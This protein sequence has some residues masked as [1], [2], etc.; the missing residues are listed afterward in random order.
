MRCRMS[1]GAVHLTGAVFFDV[2]GLRRGSRKRRRAD[3]IVSGSSPTPNT[4]SPYHVVTQ[5]ALLGVGSSA[6]RHFRLSAGDV[7]VVPHGDAHAM[8]SAPACAARRTWRFRAP[9]DGQLPFAISMGDRRT[10]ILRTWSADTLDATRGRS[11]RCC[12]AAASHPRQRSRGRGP[13]CIRRVRGRGIEGARTGGEVCSG[14]S[15][16]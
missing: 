1:C 9:S 2:R 14:D 4:S 11:T 13:R 3:S 16:S 8:S 6:R 12:R 5:G 7:I 15:A 10:S